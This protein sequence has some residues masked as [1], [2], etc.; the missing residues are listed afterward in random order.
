MPNQ[1]TEAGI[2]VATLP[3]IVTNLQVGTRTIFGADAN[4]DSNSPDGQLIGIYAQSVVDLLELIVQTYNSFN[5]DRAIGAV[6]DERVV[7]NNIVREGGD[8]TIQPIDVTVSQTVALQGLDG[9]FESIDGTGFTVQDN[10]G[11][12]FILVDSAT[13]TAGT[14]SLNFRAGE[15]GAIETIV[16]TITSFVTVVLGVT[17]VNNSSAALS[18][19]QNEE[20]DAE[21][22][23]RRQNS[24][25][26][27]SQGYLNGLY[28]AVL[29]ISGVTD[30][31]LYE[32]VA[33]SIDANGIPAHGIWLIVEGGANTDI[34]TA[35]YYKKSY[36]ANM[37]GAVGIPI[38]TASGQIFTAKFDRPTPVNLYIR[39]DIHKTNGTFFD[40]PGI[41]TYM[42]NNLDYKISQFAE[43]SSITAVALAAINA[44]S[45]GGVPI[46]MEISTDGVTYVD[47]LNTPLLSNQWVVDPTRIAIT[48]IP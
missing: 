3:E 38:T 40:L 1:I 29:A 20:T 46:N 34:A 12:R 24:V 25:A 28:G 35:I 42:Q 16:N 7:I 39:F 33:D 10:A 11:N 44:T 36:G 43:T 14:H 21:L 6:L 37:K 26:I 9:N 5:P 47:Y 45:G 32:N 27:A 22:R 19:G 48:I 4:V 8:F 31:V 30:A 18:I 23:I 15:L 17:S 13:L 2:E 41:K